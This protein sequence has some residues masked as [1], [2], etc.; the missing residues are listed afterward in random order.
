LI[1][2]KRDII[3]FYHNVSLTEAKQ[4]TTT[5]SDSSFAAAVDDGE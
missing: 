3:P 5:T 2:F 1:P 4:G